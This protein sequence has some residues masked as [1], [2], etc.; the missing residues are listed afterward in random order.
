V[1]GVEVIPGFADGLKLS[2]ALM[3]AMGLAV[4]LGALLRRQRLTARRQREEVATKSRSY[5]LV[6]VGRRLGML[7]DP[8]AVQ[9]SMVEEAVAITGAT[10]GAYVDKTDDG[11]RVIGVH[12]DLELTDDDLTRGVVGRTADNSRTTAQTRNGRSLLASAIV[13]S[14]T[15]VGVLVVARNDDR[16]GFAVKDEELLEQVAALGATAIGA[17]S[18]HDRLATMTVTD[19]LTK[20]ANRRRLDDDMAN[21]GTGPIGFVMVDID[22]FKVFNDTHGHP[23]GDDLLR[24]VA[25]LLAD[26]VRPGDVVYRYGGEEFAV[27]LPDTGVEEA[28]TVAERLRAAIY[29]TTFPGGD[30]QPS[31]RVTI[32]VGLACSRTGVDGLK[33]RADAALYEAKRGGRDRVVVAGG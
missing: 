3:A 10:A 32:S 13:Q 26:N 8:A 21:A 22:H 16:D 29:C 28:R 5:A 18:R 4:A 11:L 19:A 6:D 12:G 14:G 24:E 15:V 17:A 25:T 20:L 1:F 7:L 9:Q 23:A 31:G 30:R 27:L 2:T 33:A